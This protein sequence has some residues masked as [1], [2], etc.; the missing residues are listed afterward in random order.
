[1]SMIKKIFATLLILLPLTSLQA[2]TTYLQL[3]QDDYQLLDRLETRQGFLDRNLFMA[4]QPVSRKGA[5]AFLE[6][7][8]DIDAG[9]GVNDGGIGLT[10]IDHYL[11]AHAISVSGEWASKGDG[12]IPSRHPW[13]KGAFYNKQPDLLHVKT[14][15]F[16][17]VANPVISVSGLSESSSQPLAKTGLLASSRGVEIRARIA[18]KI[19][20]YT[21]F[22]DNQ[23][24]VPS[25]VDQYIN[26]RHPG[27]QAVPGADYYQ[28]PSAQTYDYLQARGYI[29]F[30]AIKDVV[31]VTFG[32][33][34]HF[35]GDGIR[36]L[37]LSDFAPPA[38]FLRLN[39][40]IWKLNY[41]NLYLELTP[42]YTRGGDQQL[43]HK[44]AT[45][46]HLSINATRWLNIGLFEST[47]FDRGNRFEFSYMNPVI[48][49]RSIERANGSPDNV[50]LGLN[51]KVIAA[52]HLQFYGQILFDE[53]K[54]SELFS[55]DGWFGN[56]YGVQ[57]GGKYFD[58][59][60][61][62]NL[63]VQGEL[64]IVRPFTYSHY[65]TNANYTHYN[66]PLAHPLGAG[67]QELIGLIRY[68]PL[69]GLYL[70]MK[71]LY[72]KQGL[73]TMLTTGKMSNYG[74]NPFLN[75]SENT[76][77]NTAN[78]EYGYTLTN[79]LKTTTLSV[80]VN[81]SFELR[82]NLYIDLGATHRV[83]SYDNGTMPDYT[84]NY[85]YGGLRLNIVR[86]DYDFY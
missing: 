34:K 74:S 12:A 83:V 59:F 71:V 49:Y 21:Y 47:I 82:E 22:A 51:L 86:K 76:P 81:A 25:F 36:S 28:N 84:D 38:T 19:G 30:A 26:N 64:N 66:Q 16:F 32:Y 1:M 54:S 23:E 67:F 15:N 46:H 45:I 43:P 3:G 11:I 31:N 48:L 33:D 10:N 65:D 75:Y 9:D 72:Y 68:R 17:L 53:F 35:I 55:G 7:V 14:P 24:Q 52:K 78:P 85:F 60:G 57:M 61:I 41:Q 39:T 80:N 63:D 8:R 40:R 20:V 73:D 70:S 62:P 44:Y 42:Q 50:N 69:P 79:G 2:Q 29:D 4:N 27:F 37:F 58:F 6:S 18:D 56:K 77:V 5:V 13:F